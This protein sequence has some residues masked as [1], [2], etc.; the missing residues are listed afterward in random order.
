MTNLV[1]RTAIVTGAARGLGRAYAMKMMEAGMNLVV[2][3]KGDVGETMELLYGAGKAIA[4]STDVAD[5]KS[6]A[7]MVE[8]GLAAFGRIDVLVN[9]A[10]LY[11]G[12]TGGRAE[13]IDEA[14]W[15]R[16]MAVNVKGV[17][18]CCRAVIPAMRKQGGGSIINI[19]SL[20]AV[21]GLPYALHYSA[22]K[23]AVIA[24]TRALA[25]E[26][27]RDWIR[28]NAIAPSAVLT[29]GTKEFFGGKFERGMEV[30]R[31]GQALKRNL[32]ADDLVGTVLYL[33]GDASK[34][35][36]GQTIMVDGGTHF[37]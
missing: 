33:A 36:T 15:D 29:E 24:M 5:F 22:S 9:N 2:A 21:Y 8:Q 26:L 12:L 28:V 3:D 4:V 34:F 16:C 11:G 20:A 19:A 1:G 18:N 7:A 25:R 31:E 10:A 32:Q 30:V 27:G 35:V 23:G 6:V 13:Q 37:L 17:W 14:E